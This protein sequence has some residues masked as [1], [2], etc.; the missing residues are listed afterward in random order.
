MCIAL[1]CRPPFLASALISA[2]LFL[3]PHQ[4]RSQSDTNP[5]KPATTSST[6]PNLPRFEVATIKATKTD[7]GQSMLRFTPD[8]ISIHGVPMK[9]LVREAFGVEDDRILS[10]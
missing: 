7:D 9:M 2:F 10:E 5:H 4:L 8:G 1:K 6:A 3:C